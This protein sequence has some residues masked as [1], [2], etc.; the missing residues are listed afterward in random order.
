MQQ[1]NEAERAESA[2]MRESLAETQR[3]LDSFMSEKQQLVSQLEEAQAERSHAEEELN[4]FV[5][6]HSCFYGP[7]MTAYGSLE[8]CKQEII[9]L[10]QSYDNIMSS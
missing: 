2:L 9:I 6:V 10:I 8:S 5:C 3:K 7:A 1:T 4:R